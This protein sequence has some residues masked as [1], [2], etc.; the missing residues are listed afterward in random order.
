MMDSMCTSVRLMLH[1]VRVTTLSRFAFVILGR[2]VS[3]YNI[4]YL[5]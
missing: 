4:N 1:V 5:L 2:E 3:D